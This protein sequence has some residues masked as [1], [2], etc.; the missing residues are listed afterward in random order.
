MDQHRIR[1]GWR[2]ILDLHDY[3]N[4]LFQLQMYGRAPDGRIGL[5][6]STVGHGLMH[7]GKLSFPNYRVELINANRLRQPVFVG[8]LEE[9][10]WPILPAVTTTRQRLPYCSS[11]GCGIMRAFLAKNRPLPMTVNWARRLINESSPPGIKLPWIHAADGP[12]VSS[13]YAENLAQVL[14]I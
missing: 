3:T 5:V 4:E 2:I 14:G 1:L 11:V 9:L 6:R 13:V 8:A 7:G 10:G 12:V